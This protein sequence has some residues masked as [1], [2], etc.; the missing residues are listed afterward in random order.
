M[1]AVAAMEM[2]QALPFL[3]AR[4][5]PLTE[6]LVPSLAIDKLGESQDAGS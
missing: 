1:V 5:F 3:P 4:H 6:F 2:S